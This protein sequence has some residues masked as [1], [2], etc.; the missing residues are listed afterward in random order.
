VFQGI[1]P[2][3]IKVTT[4]EVAI[5]RLAGGKIIEQWGLPDIHGLMEQLSASSK[6]R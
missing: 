4:Q 6:N 1:K 2:T 5:Y 3:G